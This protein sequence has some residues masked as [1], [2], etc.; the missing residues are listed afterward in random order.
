VQPKAENGFQSC[1][2]QTD[3]AAAIGLKNL[4]FVQKGKSLP[5]GKAL[6]ITKL[7]VVELSSCYYNFKATFWFWIR[8]AFNYGLKV[9]IN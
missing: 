5:A 1:V 7:L 4:A 3:L 9:E 2:D 6:A 8:K